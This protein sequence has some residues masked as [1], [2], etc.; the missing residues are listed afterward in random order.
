MACIGWVQDFKQL[1]D[2]NAP[3][4]STKR[5]KESSSGGGSRFALGCSP[6]RLILPDPHGFGEVF[7]PW[8]VEV[9]SR[10]PTPKNKAVSR[11]VPDLATILGPYLV[12]PKKDCM[13][14]DRLQKSRIFKQQDTKGLNCR[15]ESLHHPGPPVH[16]ARAPGAR[17]QCTIDPRTIP[18]LNQSE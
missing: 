12:W 5:V 1:V 8:Q 16:A 17:P 7:T 18:E 3:R 6:H 10:A 11:S 9:H 15:R 2:Q 14:D 4:R 13:I